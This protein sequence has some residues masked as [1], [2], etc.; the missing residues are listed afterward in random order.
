MWYV[1]LVRCDDD[2]L[3]CGITT[4]LDRR[5]EEHNA[6]E[7]AKY[8]RGRGPVTLVYFERAEDRVE[9]SRREH[10]IKQMRRSE[11]EDLLT[12]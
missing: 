1:Y 11:K 12:S 2:T 5:I 9:A 3:Y 10:E 6:G 8:T 7:G 4:D